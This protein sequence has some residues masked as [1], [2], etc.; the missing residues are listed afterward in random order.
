ML[1]T[2]RG[3]GATAVSEAQ[4]PPSWSSESGWKD[5]GDVGARDRAIRRISGEHWEGIRRQAWLVT[6]MLRL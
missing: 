3:G 6:K 4:F 5:G 1:G 2:M